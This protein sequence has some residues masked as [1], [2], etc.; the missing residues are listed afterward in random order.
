MNRPNNSTLTR[1]LRIIVIEDEDPFREELCKDLAQFPN[2]DLVGS[3]GEIDDAFNLITQTRPDGVFLDI[4]I[5]GGDAF[6]LLERLQKSN[7]GTLP[8]VAMITGFSEYA[9]Q[10]INDF[11]GCILKYLTKPFFKDLKIKLLD[12]LDAFAEVS[13][14][15]RDVIF[16]KSEGGFRRIKLEDVA[17]LEVAGSGK[18]F[19][20]MDNL[21]VK[22]DMTLAKSLEL[23]PPHFVQISRDNAVNIQKI[24]F[25]NTAQVSIFGAGKDHTLKL[26]EKFA[27][28]LKNEIDVILPQYFYFIFACNSSIL[29]FNCLNC[30][31]YFT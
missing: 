16:I 26:S 7:Y 12:C 17:Y 25:M 10:S 15:N 6:Q 2:V 30:P 31:S 3:A 11:H 4:K 23:L 20:V 5:I 1:R 29:P 18:T 14:T 22:A 8:P 9:T 28:S 27:D 24:D 13:R 21:S 19:F